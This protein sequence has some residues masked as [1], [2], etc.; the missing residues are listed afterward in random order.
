[1]CTRGVTDSAACEH[2]LRTGNT[3]RPPRVLLN[4]QFSQTRQDKIVSGFMCA[5]V[6]EESDTDLYSLVQSGH[7]TNAPNGVCSSRT[8]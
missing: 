7:A 4:T 5:E 8:F 6:A 1:M 2:L 3:V